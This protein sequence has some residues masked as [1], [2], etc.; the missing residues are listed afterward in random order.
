MPS[1]DHENA[2]YIEALQDLYLELRGGGL[3][4]SPLDSD[5]L[6][7]WRDRGLPLELAREGIRA[8][9]A[10]WAAAGRGSTRRPFLLRSADRYVEDLAAGWARRSLGVV[11]GRTPLAA[12]EVG[13][14]LEG[15]AAAL[16]LRLQDAE[17]GLR[18]AYAAA[19]AILEARRSDDVGSALLAADEAAGIRYVIALP[20]R[21]QREV[22]GKA[23]GEA[24]PRAIATKERYRA[25]LRAYLA[26]EAR[27]HG[28]WARPSDL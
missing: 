4:L 17:G 27:R 12:T 9:Y 16:R 14:P 13:S 10:A 21:S 23:M 5:R 15:I 20:R 8:A 22:V 26:E 19:L 28:Q 24:G 2:H 18:A 1:P 6:R 3:T 25:M 7:A 11:P